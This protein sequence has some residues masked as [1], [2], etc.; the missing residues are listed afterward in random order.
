M[1]YLVVLILCSCASAS[2]V[3]PSECVNPPEHRLEYCKELKRQFERRFEEAYP[4]G[5]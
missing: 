4:K 3:P 1:K 2:Y 5:K